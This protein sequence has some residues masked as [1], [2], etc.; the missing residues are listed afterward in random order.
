M[1]AQVAKKRFRPEVLGLESR[2]MLASDPGGEAVAPVTS[3]QVEVAQKKSA[4]DT[5]LDEV[6]RILAEKPLPSRLVAHLRQQLHHGLPRERVVLRILQTPQSR[7][8][9][10]KGLYQYL[11]NRDPVPAETRALVRGLQ[12]GRDG[13]WLMFRIM[14]SREYFE[15]RG[16][17]TNA[18]F[19]EASTQD[20][21]HRSATPEESARFGAFLDRGGSR[22]LVLRT[23]LGSQEFRR[24]QTELRYHSLSAEPFRP[25]AEA[26][27]LRA[28]QGSRGYSRMTARV[29]GSGAALR[30]ILMRYQDRL[31]QPDPGQTVVVVVPSPPS[32]PPHVVPPQPPPILPLDL[33][34]APILRQGVPTLQQNPGLALKRVPGSLPGWT[35]DNLAAPYNQVNIS[36]RMI[37]DMTVDY[38]AVTLNAGD[39]VLLTI[40]P[41]DEKPSSDFNVRIWGPSNQALGSLPGAEFNYMAPVAGTYILGISTATNTNY[42]FDPEGMQPT[43][44]GPSLHTYTAEFNT[45]PGPK[46]SLLDILQNYQNPAYTDQNWPAWTAAQATAYNTLTTIATAGAEAGDPD[47]RN[48]TDFRQ[49]GNQ[50]D[51]TTL[52]GWL[53]RTWMPF[54]TILNDPNNPNIIAISFAQTYGYTLAEW[55]PIAKAFLNDPSTQTAFTSVNEL[56]ENAN[57]DRTNIAA[58]LA[59]F[60]QWATVNELNLIGDAPYIASQLQQG[61]TSLNMSQPASQQS[62]WADLLTI[63]DRLA[64]IAAGAIGGPGVGFIVSGVVSGV[65]DVI[66]AQLNKQ[67][68]N[69]PPPPTPIDLDLAANNIQEYSKDAFVHAFE[70][71]TDTNFLSSTFSNYGRLQAFGDIAFAYS[72]GDTFTQANALRQAYDQ[73]TWKQLLPRMFSWR[74]AGF[75]GFTSMPNFSN[76]IPAF[77]VGGWENPSSLSP[78]NCNFWNS[79][80]WTESCNVGFQRVWGG[81]FNQATSQLQ[82]LQNAFSYSYPG[83]N[84]S[85]P[86][87][88]GPGPFGPGPIAVAATVKGQATRFY[89][90]SSTPSAPYL[91]PSLIQTACRASVPCDPRYDPNCFLRA[92][93]WQASLASGGWFIQEWVLATPNNKEISPAAAQQVFGPIPAG[94]LVLASDTLQQYGGGQYY[95]YQVPPGGFATRFEVFSQWGMDVNGFSPRSLRPALNSGELLGGYN[96]TYFDVNDVTFTALY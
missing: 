35:V 21:L 54:Q 71:L 38:W 57:I 33:N 63:F 42:P 28:F 60:N 96:Q 93:P 11:L 56:L 27:Y 20:L 46:T 22:A 86:F 52:T 10:V 70:L 81:A 79:C 30:G 41:T 74:S 58:F 75:T 80:W 66:D 91:G 26:S 72:P 85:A 12:Q 95:A 50:I 31:N 48:F 14:R 17:G 47:L 51:P 94:G 16:G 39:S 67:F 25:Q 40:V 49:V 5:F 7:A 92:A 18:G 37:D 87:Q 68:H 88:F 69:N 32:S 36:G 6:V 44:S 61:L 15:V 62:L 53:T 55:T 24:F 64:T 34:A 1:S 82:S 4:T 89:T 90:L 9:D 13:P 78:C 45:F 83:Y 76:F 73:S 84:P 3:A 59:T 2:T 19:L 65:T 8:S 43:P 77:T 23:R 29:L